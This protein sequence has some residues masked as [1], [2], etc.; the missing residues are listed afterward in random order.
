[1]LALTIGG[2]GQ[3]VAPF[4]IHWRRIES[5]S[6]T[7]PCMT[8]IAWLNVLR[9]QTRRRRQIFWLLVFEYLLVKLCFVLLLLLYWAFHDIL[10]EISQMSVHAQLSLELLKF[11]WTVLPKHWYGGHCTFRVLAEKRELLVRFIRDLIKCQLLVEVW[12]RCRWCLRAIDLVF[13][14]IATLRS[15]CLQ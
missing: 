4:W 6:R 12:R 8:L 15:L 7:D 2:L 1:M 10:C 13:Y 3:L 14:A 5:T 9:T 11:I